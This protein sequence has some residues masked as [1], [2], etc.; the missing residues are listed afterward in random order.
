MHTS[1]RISMLLAVALSL[2]FLAACK[3]S[4][5]GVKNY[6][7][8]IRGVVAAKP[9][10]VTAAARETLD[11]LKLHSLFSESTRID[12]K[13]MART[14]RDKKVEIDITRAT[15][16]SSNVSIRVGDLGD[17]ELSLQ[18]L[19]RIREKVK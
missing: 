10:R 19:D 6:V 15:D 4:E 2:A 14:A 8:T 13:V 12:G 5:P 1:R 16:T 3:T 18:I 11:E 7:G 17:Q 9:D